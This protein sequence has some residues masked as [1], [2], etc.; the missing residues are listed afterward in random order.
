[1][2][3]EVKRQEDFSPKDWLG[4][5]RL[6]QGILQESYPYRDLVSEAQFLRDPRPIF[7]MK[8]YRDSQ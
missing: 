7:L 4:Y 2:G 8:L 3:F 5:H 1:M 6:N